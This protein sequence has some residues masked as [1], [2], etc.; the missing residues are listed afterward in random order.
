[1]KKVIL[2][3]VG[4]L[5]LLVIFI[6]LDPGN[7]ATKF[8]LRLTGDYVPPKYESNSSI[9]TQ[10][11]EKEIQ[12]DRVYSLTGAKAIEELKIK[13]ISTIPF[14]HIY[15]EQKLLMTNAAGDEC[16]W[17]LLKFVQNLDSSGLIAMDSSMYPFLLD[18]LRPILIKSDQDTFDYYVFAGWA[19]WTP[20]LSNKLLEQMRTIKRQNICLSLINMDFQQGWENVDTI[21]S[22]SKK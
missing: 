5:I 7:I 20:K 14:V 18:R 19:N 9:L 10:L 1:M 3:S 13:K 4:V 2:Y 15:N 8:I 21:Q 17:T 11:E 16:K 12:F 6:F 22:M